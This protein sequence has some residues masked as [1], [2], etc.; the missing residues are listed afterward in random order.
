[1][2]PNSVKRALKEGRLQLGTAFAQ[3]RSQDVARI[4]AAAGFDW[5]FLDG[6][7]GGFDQETLQ[8]LCRIAVKVGLSPIVRVAEL[9]Y[10]LVA[11]ALDCGAEGVI[12]PRVE[13][14]ALLEKA[15]SWT[16]FP[17]VGMRGM[18]LTTMSFDF[19]PV[20]IPQ[21]MEHLNREQ[22]VVLQIET[23]KAFEARD[24]LLSV[25]NIDAVMI[26]PVDL[27]ISLGVPGEFE[28]P[29]MLATVE[30]IVESCIA[31]G[32]APGAQARNLPLAQRWK[33]M[34]MLFV[35]CSSE[36]AM[37]YERGREITT[38]LR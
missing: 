8:D 3:L 13:D 10:S 29:K 21:M 9:Q 26:G 14:P 30:K 11:R 36:T 6:E 32:V 34:G 27:T 19:E 25:P 28:H 23:V 31:H 35:G 7:H 2:K 38:T 37:L 18:G 33:Q 4:L 24:E 15:V 5:A 20:T 16:K 17:P 22:M 1:M 12:F